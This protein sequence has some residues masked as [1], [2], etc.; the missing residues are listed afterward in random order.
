MTDGIVVPLLDC[1]NGAY[2]DALLFERIDIDFAR[3][4]DSAWAAHVRAAQDFA[5]DSGLAIPT[6]EPE[7]WNWE[8]KVERSG[9]LISM[10]TL[11][12]TYQGEKQ[13]MMALLTD[14]RRC[15]LPGHESKSLVY[16]RY[17]ATAPWNL[18][19]F[20]SRFRG[21]G[22]VL[23]RA[24]VQVSIDVGFKGR[25]GLH[26]LPKSERFYECLGLSPMNHDPDTQNLKY[27]EL[28]EANVG[29]FIAGG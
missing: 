18:P 17:L 14:G 3:E 25:I 19:E 6:A 7:G 11:A 10:P 1:K 5:R 22:T 20:G 28:D 23:M 15:R 26:S 29:S 12:I 21:V 2:I 4:A 24:A 8:A 9:N 13:G 27:Y 16:V